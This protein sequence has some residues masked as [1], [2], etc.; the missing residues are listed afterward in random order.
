MRWYFFTYIFI[1]IFI[2]DNNTRICI[3][4]FMKSNECIKWNLVLNVDTRKV[5]ISY[6]IITLWCIQMVWFSTVDMWVNSNTSPFLRLVWNLPPLFPSW[7]FKHHD[8]L[9]Y[10]C[11][12][13]PQYNQNL[14]RKLRRRSMTWASSFNWLCDKYD[15]WLNFLYRIFD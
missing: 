7:K 8:Y 6:K 4:F 13:F 12:I 10:I 9:F 2:I 14:T 3:I 5:W 15:Y 11:K 1:N